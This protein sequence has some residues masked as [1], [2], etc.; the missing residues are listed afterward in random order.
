[1]ME[2]EI[3]VG[4]WIRTKKGHIY[5]LIKIDKG[6][7][8]VGH[9]MQEIKLYAKFS[10]SHSIY[11]DNYQEL[12]E[13]I[14]KDIVKH[15]K[16]IIDLIEIGDYVNGKEVKHIVMFEGFPDYPKL[17][18][19]DEKKLLPHETCENEDI[20]TIYTKE[21]LKSIEYNVKKRRAN[22]NKSCI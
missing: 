10:N 2:E 9:G 13:K 16:N 15:S 18:F 12:H 8:T 6:I 17:I 5:K 19:T 4:E 21:Q 3:E 11:A 1:M 20:K 14:N 7:I 22:E